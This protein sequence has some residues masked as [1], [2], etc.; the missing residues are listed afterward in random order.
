MR[1]AAETCWIYIWR[2]LSC[3][4]IYMYASSGLRAIH[5]LH[6]IQRRFV[7][8]PARLPSRYTHAK[9][10]SD[11]WEEPILQSMGKPLAV[12]IVGTETRRKK[13]V[14]GEFHGSWRLKIGLP[15][16]SQSLAD[17]YFWRVCFE[18]R[19]DPASRAKNLRT[20]F[21]QKGLGTRLD[22]K[23]TVFWPTKSPIFP[24]G[25]I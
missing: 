25:K 1:S 17:I 9:S 13:H 4:D 15:T 12:N 22:R 5:V 3:R 20:A 10:T 6:V 2:T 8:A 18:P 16:E 23:H 21:L 11:W 24:R 19:V 14:T 7:K